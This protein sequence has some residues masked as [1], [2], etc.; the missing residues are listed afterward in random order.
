MT[1][2]TIKAVL[3]CDS[4]R[5][6][7]ILEMDEEERMELL[8]KSEEEG[9]YGL[10][11]EVA[12]NISEDLKSW[13][14]IDQYSNPI[15]GHFGRAF[16]REN[17]G[18]KWDTIISHRGIDT[19]LE[20][21]Q[22]VSADIGLGLYHTRGGIYPE[23]LEVLE[24]LPFGGKYYSTIIR[25]SVEF[26]D[27]QMNEAERF[28]NRVYER[29]Q[30]KG[31]FNSRIEHVGHSLGGAIAQ[32]QAVKDDVFS[33]SLDSPGT[34]VVLDELLDS[35]NITSRNSPGSSDVWIGD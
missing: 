7:S 10:S 33:Q 26:F 12:T 13:R 1:S 18:S 28:P 16:V 8:S 30:K 22:D 35:G 32:I 23:L 20:I 24:K 14:V 29:L 4:K 34:K 11:N 27:G 17:E 31:K 2:N 25:K 9:G 6:K 3:S 21:V 19:D 5:K 15:N